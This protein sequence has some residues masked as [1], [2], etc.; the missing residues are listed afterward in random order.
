MVDIEI[1]DFDRARL[2]MPPFSSESS[3][4]EMSSPCRR[5]TGLTSAMEIAPIASPT[6]ARSSLCRRVRLTPGKFPGSPSDVCPR[7]FATAKDACSFVMEDQL[8]AEGS[9]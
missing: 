5:T 6:R 8:T 1:R 4:T 9:E 7:R 3:A 2:F